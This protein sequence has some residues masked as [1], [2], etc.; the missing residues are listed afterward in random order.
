M[1]SKFLKL[2]LGNLST[3]TGGIIN[4]DLYLLDTKNYTWITSFQVNPTLTT[5]I[6]PT[7]TSESQPLTGVIIA[8]SVLSSVVAIIAGIAV[9]FFI[10]KYRKNNQY[11]NPGVIE[12]PGSKDFNNMRI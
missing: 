5:S 8:I 3:Q 1:N 6:S 11:K 9:T 2:I 10:L 12:T 4:K 7:N